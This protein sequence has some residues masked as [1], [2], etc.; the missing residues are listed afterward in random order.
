V[1]LGPELVF[2]QALE[3]TREF[4]QN[5]V[6]RASAGDS[7]MALSFSRD[8]L[9]L[10]SWDPESYGVCRVTPDEMRELE[11]ASSSRPPILGAIRSHIVGADFC[12]ASQQGRDRVMKLEFRRVIGAGFFQT[13]Y[14]VFEACGRY[15]NIIILDEDNVVVE[16]AKH[17]MPDENRYRVV[18]PGNPYKAPPAVGGVSVDD[19]ASADFTCA[20]TEYNIRGIG[21]PLISALKKLS[22]PLASDELGF[23]KNAAGKP[24]YQI[25][26]GSGNYVTVSVSPLPDSIILNS[27]DSLSASRSVVVRPLIGRRVVACG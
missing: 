15:S 3:I 11:G 1:A 14:L 8:R 21:K 22:P 23:L 17:I 20:L 26:T 4:A 13:R 6:R 12:G 7:W 5:R 24:C 16:A 2:F 18:S 27:P 25:I 9:I 10:F 19:L